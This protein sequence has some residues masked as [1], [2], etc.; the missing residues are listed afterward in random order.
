MS[1]ATRSLARRAARRFAL[2][3][4]PLKRTS[5]RVQLAG[6]LLVVASLLAAVPL[7]VLAAG[8][9]RSHL[10]AAAA[11][12]A[13]GG[14]EARGVVLAD[15]STSAPPDTGAPA[16]PD[17]DVLAPGV[18]ADRRAE[19]GWRVADGGVR[20]ATVV[21]PVG[22]AVGGTVP[23]WLDRRGDLADPPPD[24]ATLRDDAAA[25][26]LAVAAGVPLVVWTLHTALR[27][28]LDAFRA[29]RWGRDWER[30]DREWRAR[31]S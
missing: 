1:R 26:G 19:I 6:R 18:A 4:G 2:G 21:V 10:D 30:V 28:V 29:R 13:A 31:Q 17:Q 7:A 11:A 25:V 3:S 8:I 5:D 24:Q 27:V 14:H 23:V 9:A 16:G 12:Q 22:T 20:H 15:A